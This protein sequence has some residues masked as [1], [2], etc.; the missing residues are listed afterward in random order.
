MAVGY[1]HPCQA[2]MRVVKRNA[3]SRPQAAR[4][5]P[6]ASSLDPGRPRFRSPGRRYGVERSTR[7]DRVSFNGCDPVPAAWFP[8]SPNSSSSIILPERMAASRAG[9]YRGPAMFRTCFGDRTLRKAPC[10]A[11]A[12]SSRTFEDLE[13]ATG[14]CCPDGT[15]ARLTSS[16]E[17]KFNLPR[18]SQRTTGGNE[19]ISR[20]LQGGT[21]CV[22]GHRRGWKL[23]RGN[24][25]GPIGLRLQRRRGT[26][27]AAGLLVLANRYPQAIPQFQPSCQRKES[28]DGSV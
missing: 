15:D 8:R 14:T 24:C 11:V 27:V 16:P 18:S 6:K 7:M 4:R 25:P 20:T 19:P 28:A 13:V 2:P 12:R 1:E 5:G 21:Q 22:A 3:M 10:A 26:R 17:C 9:E 23:S